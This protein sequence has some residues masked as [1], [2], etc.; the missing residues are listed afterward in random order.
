M[1]VV[2][3]VSLKMDEPCVKRTCSAIVLYY[4]K[5]LVWFSYGARERGGLVVESD[6]EARGRGFDTYLRRVVSLSKEAFTPRKVLVIPRKRWF[7][8]DM[9]EIL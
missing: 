8:P 1:V 4:E 5:C 6:S 2:L 9:T 3:R 7:R